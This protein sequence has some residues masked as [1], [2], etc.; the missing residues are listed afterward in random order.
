LAKVAGA[1]RDG[2]SSWPRV[3]LGVARS[4]VS[5]GPRA[6]RWP[7]GPRWT[8]ARGVVH[9][10]MVDRGRIGRARGEWGGHGRGGAMAVLAAS[11]LRGAAVHGRP[12]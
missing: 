3:G 4:T 6:G 8:A 2:Q 5:C 1:A 9:R 10:S 11:S 7:T 12:C